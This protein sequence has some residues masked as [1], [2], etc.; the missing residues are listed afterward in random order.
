[1]KQPD[2]KAAIL[3]EI[4]AARARL[5]AAAGELRAAGEGVKR[6][7]DVPGRI[8]ESFRKHRPAWL[9]CAALFG[10]LLSKLPSRKKTVYVDR[11]T[12]EQY[13]NG[14]RGGSFAWSAVKTV[15]GLAKP[16]ITQ[17]AG[18]RLAEWAARQVNGHNQ[19]GRDDE[20]VV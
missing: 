3:A 5:T 10:L 20:P 9:G 17:L 14:S 13:A 6:S 15:A 8:G 2:D 18:S 1:M 4:T 16:L 7:F 11:E 19:A 12:G